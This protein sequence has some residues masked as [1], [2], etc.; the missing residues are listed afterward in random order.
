MAKRA[1]DYIPADIQ[2]A[3]KAAGL[4]TPLL[5]AGRSNGHEDRELDIT[6]AELVKR[7]RERGPSSPS[8]EAPTST[9]QD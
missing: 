1:R 4:S 3:A 6:P 7:G 9:E 8:G 2:E 5:Y